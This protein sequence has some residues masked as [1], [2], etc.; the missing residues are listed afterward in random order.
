MAKLTA[1]KIKEQIKKI[2]QAIEEAKSRYQDQNLTFIALNP[3]DIEKKLK[4]MKSPFLFYHAWTGLGVPA[5]GTVSNNI[6]VWNP[7]P[8]PVFGVLAHSWVGSGSV[9]PVVGTFLLNVDT[10]F[11]RLTEP[12]FAGKLDALAAGPRL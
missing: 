1:A 8:T 9:D 7:D 10:R 2:Q 11:P 12:R 4:R 5:G 6:G 3:K